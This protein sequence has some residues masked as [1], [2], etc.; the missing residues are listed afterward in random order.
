MD[1]KIIKDKIIIV[2]APSPK[3]VYQNLY[4]IKLNNTDEKYVKSI[5]NF[6][7][8][9]EKETYDIAITEKEILQ[10]LK[11][12]YNEK[13]LLEQMSCQPISII[14]FGMM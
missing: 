11:D 10:S 7:S 2:N 13:R 3:N 1:G 14:K 4:S 5:N 9:D 8:Q 12:L 6:L